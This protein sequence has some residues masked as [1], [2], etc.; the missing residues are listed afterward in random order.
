MWT[1][2]LKKEKPCLAAEITN[3]RPEDAM[4]KSCNDRRARIRLG[5]GGG[6][7]SEKRRA[8]AQGLRN[9]RRQRLVELN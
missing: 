5:G 9:Y 7:R 6:G 1:L 2:S 8:L 3:E 4:A